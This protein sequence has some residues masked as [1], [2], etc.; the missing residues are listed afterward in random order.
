MRNQSKSQK[1]PLIAESIEFVATN[2]PM[3][4]EI[5]EIPN[6]SGSTDQFYI[7]ETDKEVA[8]TLRYAVL[9]A[10]KM[11]GDTTFARG[12]EKSMRNGKSL[13][14]YADGNVLSDM[15]LTG[16]STIELPLGPIKE[17]MEKARSQGKAVRLCV[18]K[19]GVP[20]FFG[21]DWNEQYDA[22]QKKKRK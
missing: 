3:T 14:A 17:I 19:G 11:R 21:N 5:A 12:V 18:P 22:L 13:Q 9:H 10:T 6:K 2:G 16:Q 20:I 4:D 1:S 15:D 7:S 8:I